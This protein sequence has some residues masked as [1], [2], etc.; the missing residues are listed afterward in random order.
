M[1]WLLRCQIHFEV[2]KCEE[3]I[4]QLQV[5]EQH[6]LKAIQLDDHKCYHEQ[7]SHSLNRLRL[8]AELY[9]I[10]ERLEDQVAVI[11]EQSIKLEKNVKLESGKSLE[12]NTRSLLMR[13]ADLLAKQEFGNVMESETFKPNI[14]K[15]HEDV[16][17]KLVAKSRN[18]TNCT[19][20]CRMH[21]ND[22]LRDLNRKYEQQAK[23]E[24]ENILRSDYKERL[25]LWFD[26]CKIARKQQLWDVCRVASRFCILYD[27]DKLI[28]RFI[29]VNDSK[30]AFFNKELMRNL[31]E[32]H[33]IKAEVSFCRIFLELLRFSF[34]IR[35][36]FSGTDTVHKG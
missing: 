33:F 5:A 27:D 31:A 18:Y 7:L 1:E 25:K 15:L 6:L 26:L 16:V 30:T 13:A 20:K 8:R 11:I 24:I 17:S 35:K 32:A 12:I 10:P 23:E 22:R 34:K 21:I 9:K 14:G 29:P 4:E 2:S 19:A 3:E 28:S 36:Q